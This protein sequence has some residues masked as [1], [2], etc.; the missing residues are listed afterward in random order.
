[1]SMFDE[2]AAL[3]DRDKILDEM[4]KIADEYEKQLAELR[5]ALEE[6]KAIA[7]DLSYVGR[8]TDAT[9]EFELVFYGWQINRAADFLAKYGGQK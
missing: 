3:S 4:G 5:S 7:R 9:D 6:A 1:M 2:Q 8:R